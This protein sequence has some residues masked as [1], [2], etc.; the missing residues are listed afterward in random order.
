M[1]RLLFSCLLATLFASGASGQ[2][3]FSYEDLDPGAASIVGNGLSI[4]GVDDG[5]RTGVGLVDVSSATSTFMSLQT[6]PT[7]IDV[8]SF[9]GKQFAGFAETLIPFGT[10]LNTGDS[11]FL[12]ID[13]FNEGVGIDP[14]NGDTFERFTAGFF[15]ATAPQNEW[16]ELSSTGTIPAMTAAG[17]AVDR[18]NAS[19][20]FTDGGFGGTPNDSGGGTFSLIDN[21]SFTISE[22]PPPDPIFYQ[23][24]APD[25]TVTVSNAFIEAAVDPLDA[26][27]DV[28]LISL[29]GAAPFAN[30]NSGGTADS[31]S[32]AGEKFRAAFD[33]LVPADTAF[34]DGQDT[35]WVQIGFFDP[36]S[37]AVFGGGNS[38]SGGFPGIA[39]VADGTWRTIEITGVIPP[40]TMGAAFSIV[41]SDNGFTNGVADTFGD[42]MFVDNLIFEAIDRLPGDFNDDG[43]VDAADYTVWR[44]N[45]GTTAP[46]SPFEYRDATNFD[47]EAAISHNG[48]G[49]NGVDMGDYLVWRNNFG[50]TASGGGSLASASVPEPSALGLLLCGSVVAASRRRWGRPSSR[51]AAAH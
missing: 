4:T 2:V 12:Q 8:S 41:M 3:L 5:G 35:F 39:A 23:N 11:I 22:P 42:V 46:T 32:F 16:L 13:Y 38:D 51:D 47:G 18:V 6:D 45:L 17:D 24:D 31:A 34:Q 37:E 15:G 44:D 29:G 25:D 33:Y 14:M 28:G 36:I 9:I 40:D 26:S 50:A 1:S 21:F 7:T 19:V 20:V 49:M 43:V 30:I 10:T 27:N 48:D